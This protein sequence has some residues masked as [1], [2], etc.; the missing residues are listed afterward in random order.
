[1]ERR[2]P[3]HKEPGGADDLE[4]EE[5]ITPGTSAIVGVQDPHDVERVLQK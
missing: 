4:D 2:K 5:E 3:T 1:M